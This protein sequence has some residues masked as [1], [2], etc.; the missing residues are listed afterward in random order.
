MKQDIN[1][2]EFKLFRPITGDGGHKI[3]VVY[4]TLLTLGQNNQAIK[5]ATDALP[6]GDRRVMAV[7]GLKEDEIDRLSTPDFNSLSAY[8]DQ[9]RTQASAE[10]FGKR[11]DPDSPTLALPISVNGGEE[12]TT[13][14]LQVP[15]VKQI[16]ARDLVSKEVMTRALWLTSA[17]TGAGPDDLLALA[18]P[19][20]LHLQLRL[21][22]FLQQPAAF[23]HSG[24]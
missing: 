13:L 12:V 24:T 8:V 20:W 9:M 22:D 5:E 15:S 17:C 10:F 2:K 21:G 7:T 19:D 16:R 3:E 14:S 11:M 18:M 23:F 1:P 4:A 6:A